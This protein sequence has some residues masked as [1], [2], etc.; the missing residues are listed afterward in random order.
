MPKSTLVLDF[1]KDKVKPCFM[2]AKRESHREVTMCC[3]NSNFIFVRAVLGEISRSEG[4]CTDGMTDGMD[5]G[6]ERKEDEGRV[7]C[8]CMI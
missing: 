7:V 4:K 8:F 5:V 6:C 2:R 3:T 1:G